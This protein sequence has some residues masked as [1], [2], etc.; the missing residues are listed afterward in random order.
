MKNT[1]GRRKNND[2]RTSMYVRTYSCLLISPKHL[3]MV[4]NKGNSQLIYGP[5]SQVSFWSHFL[6]HS[7]YVWSEQPVLPQKWQTKKIMGVFHTNLRVFQGINRIVDSVWWE[8]DYML[9]KG[10]IFTSFKNSSKI[11]FRFFCSF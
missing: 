8:L 11:V 1:M 7:S 9:L 4:E 2:Q 5:I 10:S 6:H 3:N